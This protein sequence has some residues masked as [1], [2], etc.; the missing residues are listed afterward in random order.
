[1]RVE[2]RWGHGAADK[3]RC[4]RFSCN[5]VTKSLPG[6][7][8]Q[9]G[10]GPLPPALLPGAGVTLVHTGPCVRP[11]TPGSSS[12]SPYSSPRRISGAM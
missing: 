3:V 10:S 8:L 1:M 4:V 7:C 11:P 12:H 6:R 5:L 2:A 9:A